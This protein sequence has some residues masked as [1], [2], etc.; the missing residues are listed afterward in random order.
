MTNLPLIRALDHVAGHVR[1]ACPALALTCLVAWAAH[2]PPANADS[3]AVEADPLIEI[4]EAIEEAAPGSIELYIVQA[5]PVDPGTLNVFRAPAPSAALEARPPRDG[6]PRNVYR[7]TTLIPVVS[8]R[9]E[10]HQIAAGSMA[11]L[12]GRSELSTNYESWLEMLFGLSAITSRGAIAKAEVGFRGSEFSVGLYELRG[13]SVLFFPFAAFQAISAVYA[14][15]W[16]DG[17]A[18]GVR[19]DTGF[20]MAGALWNLTFAGY[21]RLGERGYRFSVGAGLGVAPVVSILSGRRVRN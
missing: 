12:L 9:L 2:A 14:S 7:G 18:A 19:Y 15:D 8:V 16:D 20:S 11:L 17:R 3:T 13:G 21:R 4:G 6:R 1:S 5:D 10:T